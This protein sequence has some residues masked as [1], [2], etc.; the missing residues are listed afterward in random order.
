MNPTG[1]AENGD[2]EVV[3]NHSDGHEPDGPPTRTCSHCGEDKTLYDY[4][5][6]IHTDACKKKAEKAEKAK[7][8]KEDKAKLK[9][10][11]I[12]RKSTT[13]LS[14]SGSCSITK[15]YKRAPAAPLLS[16]AAHSLTA[17]DKVQGEPETSG[18]ISSTNNVDFVVDSPEVQLVEVFHFSTF[19]KDVEKTVEHIVNEVVRNVKHKCSGFQVNAPFENIYAA[20][21]CHQ[22][23]ELDIV[24]EAQNLHHRSCMES[25]YVT[26]DGNLINEACENLRYSTKLKQV[27]DRSRKTIEDLSLIK[28]NNTFL[29]HSQLS[30]KAKKM[31]EEKEEYRLK[32]LRVTFKYSKLCSTLSLHERFLVSIAE[33]NVPRLQQLVKVALKNNRKMPYIL[34]KVMAVIEGIYTPNPSQDDKD[35]AF[36]VLKFGGP[37]L[38]HILYKAGILPHESTAYRMA[39]KCPPIVSSV[40]SSAGECFENN[41]KFSEVGKC[42]V[43]IKMDET[44]VNPT[45]AYNQRENEAV[46]ACYQHGKDVKL[47]LDDFSDCEN[48]QLA[49]DTGDLHVP[50]ECAV[51]GANA[52]NEVDPLQPAI[53]W[54]SC[55]KDDT[56]GVIDIIDQINEVMIRKYGHPITN[57]CTDGDANRRKVSNKVMTH[58]ASDFDWFWH[59][60]G[61]PLV[62][63]SVG[64][65]GETF[66]FDPKHIVKRCWCM[67]LR[68]K[69]TMKDV[70]LTKNLL[71]EV[72][73]G[74]SYGVEGQALNPKDKQNVKS[75]TSFLL[76]FIEGCRGGKYPYSLKPLENELNMLADIFDGLLHFFV[77]SDVSIGEQITKVGKSAY[78]LYHLY[79]KHKTSLMPSQLYHDLQATFIDF[80]FCCAKSK[81]LCPSEPFYSV[82]NGSDSAERW[83]GNVRLVY[84]GSNFTALDMVNAARSTSAADMILTVKH[85]E[86]NSSS[87]VQR[88]LNLD[89][90]NPSIWQADKL[91]LEDVN[92][93]ACWK[94]GLY[95][96]LGMISPEEAEKFERSETTL[97]CPIKSGVVVGV[98]AENSD[99]L[100]NDEEDWSVEDDLQDGEDDASEDDGSGDEVE[101]VSL[102]H[103][104]DETSGNFAEMLGDPAAKTEPF[105]LIDGKRVYK[106]TCLKTIMSKEQL[107]KDRLRRVQGKSQH[108]SY[109]PA[110]D[111][112]L[113]L[114]NGD[115]VL[116][117]DPK[118]G[119]IVVNIVSMKKG[120]RK[121][122]QID[123]TSD[124]SGLKDVQLVVKQIDCELIEEKLYWKGTTANEN[125][126]IVG[127]NCLP[128]KP[129]IDLSPPEGMTKFYFDI[130]LLRDMGV[131]LQLTTP[132]V[133]SQ[134][135]TTA[136]VV[137]KRCF[138]CNKV[139]PLSDMR[140]HVGGHI[141]RKRLNGSNIC[142]FC[143]RSV[144]TTK[145]V[146]SS[147]KMGVNYYKI[148]DCDCPHFS[149]YGRAK[150]FNK[151]TNPCTNRIDRCPIDGCLTDVWTYN[152][153]CHFNEKHG[154]ADFPEH[155]NLDEKEKAHVKTLA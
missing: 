113:Y 53:I 142:G 58:D 17:T 120:N 145:L 128:I 49:L 56:D 149:E 7:K 3:S 93:K 119:Q 143:G 32:L 73:D 81:E 108:P 109:N 137:T 82:Q 48:L 42:L 69:V 70:V 78:L 44:F 131:H 33:N 147:H 96:A 74:N 4:N 91:T 57:F 66:N 133:T 141:Q 40:K 117:T 23:L 134:S 39:R 55:S 14:G 35:M 30:Q 136:G 155:M 47:K 102:D 2:V 19:D 22:L 110:Q 29:S 76:A 140:A 75:A 34:S 122:Q 8:A 118:V 45:L 129:S 28:C 59:V 151:K 37:S 15:F 36:L 153:E 63:N 94:S 150:K 92:I 98:K 99:G 26:K 13:D 126:N 38:L 64:R 6:K 67:L 130:N 101:E 11:N 103:A 100:D 144:C 95:Q 125:R 139:L 89:Y 154:D 61:L 152:F 123:I 106:T 90:S 121:V 116:I 51:V 88:R 104:V 52:L 146:V 43:S 86:W 114:M 24:I 135:S 25:N 85:P 18:N 105:F 132:S 97:R 60:D 9:K 80:L 124:H 138:T 21:A 16:A 20:V 71:K 12:K 84:K 41:V 107:S 83:F 79:Q 87:R 112:S 46:G 115:P 5:W 62:D 1:T 54:P 72:I 111:S 31:R 77:F 148:Q 27:I 127:D 65:N 68:E 10:S 50:K